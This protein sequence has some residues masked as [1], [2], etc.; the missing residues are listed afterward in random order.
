MKPLL[1]ILFAALLTFSSCKKCYDCPKRDAKHIV[2]SS[3]EDFTICTGDMQYEAA[4]KGNAVYDRY[5]NV[6]HC[7]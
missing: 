5:G 2:S 7:N 4:R 3:I 6:V 1:P